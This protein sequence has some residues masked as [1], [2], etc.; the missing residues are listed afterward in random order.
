LIH[1]HGGTGAHKNDIDRQESEKKHRGD[2]ENFLDF[3]KGFPFI[4][5]LSKDIIEEKSFLHNLSL[6]SKPSE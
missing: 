1:L 2:K 6:N 5:K 3:Q 4:K